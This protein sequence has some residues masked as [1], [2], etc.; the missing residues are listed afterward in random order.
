PPTTSQ[1]AAA[2]APATTGMAQ[3]ARAT[4]FGAL[5]REQ[6][7]LPT[8]TAT[9]TVQ[10]PMLAQAP[11][12]AQVP[13]PKKTELPVSKTVQASAPKKTDLLPVSKTVDVPLAAVPTPPA[14]APTKSPVSVAESTSRPDPLTQP[15]TYTRLPREMEAP[16]KQEMTTVMVPAPL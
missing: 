3:P 8:E 6:L 14:P 4:G 9:A 2:T 7:G 15:R 5:L 10:A 13:A 16:T 12:P 1:L 11:M